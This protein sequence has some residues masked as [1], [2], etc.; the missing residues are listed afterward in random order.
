MSKFEFFMT[1]YGL[2]LGLGVAELMLGFANLLRS[3][4]RPVLGLLTPLLGVAVFLQIMA[5][6]LDAWIKLQDVSMTMGGLALPTLIGVAF[7]F[8][9]TI[10]VP[11]D[12]EE[13]P[14]L[15][16]YFRA[17]RRWTIGLMLLINLLIVGYEVPHVQ[18]LIAEARWPN[19]QRYFVT[20]SILF[21]LHLVALFARP[22]WAIAAALAAMS[23]FFVYFYGG[24]A[25][26]T[27]FT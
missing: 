6:F 11:R 21:A 9:G 3:R 19:V 2:L 27:I 5:T 13:W 23:L 7:F 25:S 22:R 20:N 4:T 18:R 24:F 10:V 26:A 16:E 14:R 12:G 15:D 1:F 8:L 17:N